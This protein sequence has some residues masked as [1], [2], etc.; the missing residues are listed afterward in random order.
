[1]C[2]RSYAQVFDYSLKEKKSLNINNIIKSDS[3]SSQDFERLTHSKK[4][5]FF[6]GYGMLPS[7]SIGVFYAGYMYDVFKK[8]TIEPSITLYTR[9][10]SSANAMIYYHTYIMQN[11]VDVYFGGG[12][13][14]LKYSEQKLVYPLLSIK[15]DINLTPQVTLGIT[16]LQP[17][18][19]ESSYYFIPVVPFTILSLGY[20]F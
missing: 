2:N 12:V 1:M 20:K 3:L 16:L 18:F 17:F 9:N 14:V 15:A 10:R 7:S 19:S 4:N 8:M 5:K 6:A 13:Q 11:R